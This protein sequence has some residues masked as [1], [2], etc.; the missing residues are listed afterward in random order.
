MD[1]LDFR[2]YVV[3]HRSVYADLFSH[4]PYVL[5]NAI[6][7]YARYRSM[8]YNC[9]EEWK[10][11]RQYGIFLFHFAE[12]QNLTV[13]YNTEPEDN[14]WIDW[15]MTADAM[16]IVED[17]KT[18]KCNDDKIMIRVAQWCRIWYPF[19]S[20]QKHFKESMIDFR[21]MMQEKDRTQS[22][23]NL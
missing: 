4:V 10:S 6:K 16:S 22:G 20:T 13:G 3:R 2:K 19:F 7:S 23:N 14:D 1:Y 21:S 15:S 5:L 11:I 9:V 12:L 18:N 8:V 17:S